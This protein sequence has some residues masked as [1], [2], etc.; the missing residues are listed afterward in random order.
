MVNMILQMAGVTALYVAA[1]AVLWRFWH[2]KKEHSLLQK[3]A[4]GLFYGL[5]SVA[6]NHFGIFYGNMILNVRDI[7]PLA[8][9][10]FFDPIAGILS[11]L[12]GGIERFVIGEFFEIGWFTRVACSVSTCLAGILAAG[13]HLV[14]YQ[15]KRPSVIH[16][17]LLGAGME[18]FHMYAVFITNRDDMS[19][20]Y[21][22][23]Q[24]CALPMITFT[25]LG[26][27]GCSV[28]IALMNGSK[29]RVNLKSPKRNTPLDTRFQRWLM[30]ATVML[31]GF[32]Y[33][34]N[35]SLLTN[36]AYENHKNDLTF[37]RYQYQDSYRQ[38][39]NLTALKKSLNE[40]N[41][42]TN[43][44][45]LLV[46]AERMLR[47]TLTGSN[48]TSI[49][50]DPDEVAMIVEHADGDVFWTNLTAYFGE[51]CMCV[52]GKLDNVFYVLIATPEEYIY[53]DRESQIMETLFLEILIFTA[54]YLVTSMMVE[55]MI[56][57]NLDKVNQSLGRITAGHLNETVEV[58]ESSE[59]TKLSAEINTTV[60]ALRGYIDAAENRM[61]EELKLA[62]AIQDA[63]LPKNFNLPTEH[64]EIHAL[65]TPAR[66]VGGD[67]YD[68][69]YV[70]T[71]TVALAI[72]DVS[73]KG[74]PASLFMMRAKTA[75]KNTARNGLGPAKILEN[76]N[77]ILCEGN[78]AEMF[79][80]VWI[81]ILDL[82][83]GKMMC[84]NAGHEYP[85]IMRA[86]SGYE[87]LKDKHG[88]VLAGYEN[89]P[90]KEYEITLNPGD[91]LFVYTDGVPEAVNENEEQ[92]GTGRMTE[93]LTRLKDESQE[94]M[95]KGMLE[96]IRNFAGEAE[97]FDDITMLGITYR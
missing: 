14:V 74:I 86:G 18:V 89:V 40:S 4:I 94:D 21:Y 9:G 36:S 84:A 88:L 56:V 2:Q 43:S 30:V 78:D 81:G 71:D 45:Y 16:C 51:K 69:F 44:V 55:R 97:Q 48:A 41:N 17:L 73:G 83:T 10:L 90:M 63:A 35:Y 62:A 65:M 25:A 96:S 29:L 57:R 22:V 39:K 52:S 80:T 82:N 13:L 34:L 59:F 66:S 8:A 27:I 68:F 1:T 32:S 19:T 60:T 53:E 37:Q 54:L 72:A 47:I 77:N 64:L 11:G 26:L 79:V 93:E 75:I 38:N 46:N 76:V 58:E 49:P 6:A 95:L 67:F 3:L 50:M 61:K 20:A 42:S 31:F 92:Y 70:G 15:G 33:L 23:V 7:G 85:A 24:T 28:M 5:C 12:I 91:R 87:L